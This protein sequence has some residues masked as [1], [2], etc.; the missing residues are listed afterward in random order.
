[1]QTPP[2]RPVFLFAFSND[3]AY[4]LRLKEEERAIR[5]VLG[6]ADRRKEIEYKS[7]GQANLD[8]IYNAFNRYNNQIY[9]FQIYRGIA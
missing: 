9:I 6:E 8:D 7:I 3:S 1:M 2:K 4:R 5:N